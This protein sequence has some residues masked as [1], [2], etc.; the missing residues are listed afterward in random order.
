MSVEEDR[1]NAK[2][3]MKGY[4]GVYR[5]CD[6]NPSR[7]C[8]GQSYGRYLGMG[9]AGS[10]ASFTNN[11]KALV[12]LKLL[13][14]VVGKQFEPTTETTFLGKKISMPIMAASVT[15]VNSFGGDNAIT[16]KE[17]CR[18]IVLGCKKAGTIGFRGDTYTYSLEN[19]FGIDAIAEAD[20]WGIKIVKPREQ[21]V[22]N[23]F[24][25]KAEKAKAIAVGI[26]VDGCGSLIMA[27]HGKHVFNKTIDDLKELKKATKLPFIVKGL[28]YAEDAKEAV[29]AGADVIVV[30]NHGGR[31]LDHSPGTAEVLPKVVTELKGKTTILVDGGIRTGYDV[32][33]MLALGADGVLIGRD[34]IRAAVGGGI[35]GVYRIMD[36]FQ[37]T[38]KKAMKM[39]ACKTIQEI[40]SDI[41]YLEA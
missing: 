26:D 3:K 2:E 41:I 19:S 13:M 36:H 32:L 21:R 14:R 28:M 39:T 4:C 15:G 8:Q 40:S 6:G 25:K 9:G 1:R 37:K 16:E 17:L 22:I 23:D 31:V 5:E 27:K 12:K 34:V 33:K 38:L 7:L 18:A 10:G 30:S 35:D 29:E 11:V 20:G 24:Y